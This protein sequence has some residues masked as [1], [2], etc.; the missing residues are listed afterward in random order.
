MTRDPV[1]GLN[2]QQYDATAV[3]D[4]RGKT[5]YFCSTRCRAVFVECPATFVIE[6]AV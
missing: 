1:C 5:Y 6:V 4:Y 3:S 2:I